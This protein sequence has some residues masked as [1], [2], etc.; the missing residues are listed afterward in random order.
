MK[1]IPF[2]LILFISILASA[3]DYT[4]QI[5]KQYQDFISKSQKSTNGKPPAANDSHFIEK[6]G[7]CLGT[8][9]E[10]QG[11]LNM[12]NN[13]FIGNGQIVLYKADGV[14][15]FSETG[16]TK[17]SGKSCLRDGDK[18]TTDAIA[19][20]IAGL[21]TRGILPS[22]DDLHKKQVARALSACS[23]I[24]GDV[25]VV[26]ATL[27]QSLGIKDYGKNPFLEKQ[28]ATK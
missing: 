26:S 23:T 12:N 17:V 7:T 5:N 1:T 21:G 9:Q 13:F 25:P 4:D 19:M 28:K 14:E 8:L 27:I 6:Y 20:I 11:K 2:L 10:V 22:G 18:K 16:M 24:G 15:I 3:D